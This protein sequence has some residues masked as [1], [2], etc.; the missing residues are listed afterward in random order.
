MSGW[1]GSPKLSRVTLTGKMCKQCMT[2]K[3]IDEFYERHDDRSRDGRVIY[4]K[5]C[6]VKNTQNHR[7]K[8]LRKDTINE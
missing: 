5:K 3:P 2:F 4:C 1:R 8:Q 7:L 6:C